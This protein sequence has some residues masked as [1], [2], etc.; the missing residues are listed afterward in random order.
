MIVLET[1]VLVPS[2]HHAAGSRG[3]GARWEGVGVGRGAGGLAWS[4]EHFSQS[5]R[6]QAST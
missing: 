5:V 1:V 6:R 4:A 3:P 2:E